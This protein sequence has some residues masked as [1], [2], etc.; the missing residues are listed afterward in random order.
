MLF[1]GDGHARNIA[2]LLYI[3]TEELKPLFDKGL[4]CGDEPLLK[5]SYVR[6]SAQH[7]EK[8]QPKKTSMFRVVMIQT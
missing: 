6:V 8:I 2:R 1:D 3:G 4:T 7:V 5:I